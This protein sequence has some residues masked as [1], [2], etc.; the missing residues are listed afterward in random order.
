MTTDFMHDAYQQQGGPLPRANGFCFS[1]G[2]IGEGTETESDQPA[3]PQP[4]L[5]TEL[6]AGSVA[7]WY[8]QGYIAKGQFTLLSALWKCGKTTLL[9]LLFKALNLGGSFAGRPVKPCR[10]LCVSEESKNRWAIRREKHGATPNVRLLCRPFKGRPNFLD[11]QLLIKHLVR[12]VKQWDIQLVAFD[13]LTNL[14]PVVHENDAGEVTAALMELYPLAE[15]AAVLCDHHLRKGGGAE[16]T[17]SRGSGALTSFVDTIVEMT[18]VNPNDPND[19]KRLLTGYGRD[20][21]TPTELVIE[22]NDDGNDYTCLGDGPSV[23]T[24]DIGAVLDEV[25]PDQPPGFC[26]DDIKAGWPNDK[27]PRKA[28]VLKALKDGVAAGRFQRT[29]TGVKNRAPLLPHDHPYPF[30]RGL[31]HNHQ[32][33]SPSARLETSR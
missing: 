8:W 12:C 7:D 18:R 30:R 31:S 9:S 4:E 24:A 14:W 19:R 27:T 23:Q 1:S 15:Q 22:L 3:L 11:W 16:G 21:E 33:P 26:W 32:Q 10:V 17:G 6:T 13:T 5:W 2:P 29:G 28:K 25:L 20:E